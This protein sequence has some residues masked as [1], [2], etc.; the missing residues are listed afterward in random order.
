[1]KQQLKPAARALWLGKTERGV[2]ALVPLYGT[3]PALT[4]T[5]DRLE[6]V[7]LLD[8]AGRI[9]DM[10]ERYRL[11][12]SVIVTLSYAAIIL[13]LSVRYGP[14]KT[15]RIVM[16]PALAAMVALGTLG[17]LGMPLNIF[18]LL[19]LLLVLGVG[20][21][22][23]LFLEEGVEHFDTTLVAIG[24]SAFTTMVSFGLLALSATPAVSAFGITVLIGIGGS[25]LFALILADK[26]ITSTHS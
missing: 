26:K 25:L 22:Y 5:I 10:L 15:L 19:A 4:D 7:R 12:A 21:D 20:I 6:G 2:A 8:N 3:D 11:R 23:T 16:P 14:R 17:W 18:H 9:S 1:M 13:L 24:L